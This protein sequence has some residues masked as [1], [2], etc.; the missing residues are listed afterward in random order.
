VAI[1]TFNHEVT[2]IGDG[3]GQ[4]TIVSGDRL[5]D[6]EA[7]LER[8]RA[9]H[10]QAPISEC[11]RSLDEKLFKLEEGGP[12]AL[13]PAVV[14]AL[15]M[16]EGK[17]GSRIVVCTDGLA[18]VGL[19][20]VEGLEDDAAKDAADQF[21]DRVG[22]LAAE[23]GTCIDVVGIRSEGCDLERLGRMAE[24][25]N[26]N[27]SLVDPLNL[28][29]DF[30]GMFANPVVATNVSLKL[31]LHRGLRFRST[32]GS[33]AFSASADAT[34]PTA[35]SDHDSVLHHM[36]GNVTTDTELSFEY[37]LR[38]SAERKALGIG[39]LKTL[40]F[41]LQITY[42]RLN[43][44]KCV[45]VM[46]QSQQ[47]TTN[48]A[49][50]EQEAD[51]RVLSS[52]A[53]QQTAKMA[54]AGVYTQSR[55]N[56]RVWSNFMTDIAANRSR[57]AEERQRRLQTVNMYASD[58]NELDA[59]VVGAQVNEEAEY[60]RTYSDE[61]D[62]ETV[63]SGAFASALDMPPAPKRNVAKARRELRSKND[64]LSNRIQKTSKK[65]YF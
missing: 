42:T 51:L 39:E 14:T 12:T 60:G 65:S 4:P 48:R 23:Q 41:Q 10:E 30:H 52:H 26:G 9:M 57:T 36:V 54:S 3:R 38:P 37:Q 49:E 50:A 61:E 63:E 21:Y 16:C 59:A 33:P 17:P 53:A 55:G 8:G 46:T 18:N 5:S 11:Q 22:Q 28:H 56:M 2:V 43:G 34:A 20:N 1:V 47:V 32:N 44:M 24:L 58:M 62:N 6:F 35:P 64:D 31:L 27:V 29:N 40:P 7:L 25:A 19:G 13:G 15:G 45:R